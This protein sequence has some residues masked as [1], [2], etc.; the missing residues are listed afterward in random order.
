MPDM[1]TPPQILGTIPGWITAMTSTG[2]LGAIG[3]FLR[4]F[5]K[6]KEIDQAAIV[7][8]RKSEQEDRVKDSAEMAGLRTE[9]R[10]LREYVGA[11]AEASIKREALMQEQADK[12]YA[13]CQHENDELRDRVH[14]LEAKISGMHR[15]TLQEQ[16]SAARLRDAPPPPA[17]LSPEIRHALD[18]LDRVADQA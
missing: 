3:L 13:Q 1:S 12:R 6:N 8:A 16:V 11:Q 17:P 14:D 18:D 4:A 15:Q 10:S 7:A 2:I 9:L 5:L